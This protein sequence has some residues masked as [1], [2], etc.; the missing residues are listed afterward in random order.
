MGG[1]DTGETPQPGTQV[2]V[3]SPTPLLLAGTLTV[4]WLQLPHPEGS[5]ASRHR[6]PGG[7]EAH[8]RPLYARDTP[9][10][11]ITVMSGTGTE[12]PRWE[13]NRLGNQWGLQGKGG[14][15]RSEGRGRSKWSLRANLDHWFG[16]LVRPRPPPQRCGRPLNHAPRISGMPTTGQAP[17]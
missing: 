9:G 10:A 6:L 2:W 5:S 7:G 3:R 8:M 17:A 13:G 11:R 15:W 16:A 12:V 14:L 1:C 4:S